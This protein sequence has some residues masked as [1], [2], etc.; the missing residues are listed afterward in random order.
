MVV[1][2]TPLWGV[3]RGWHWTAHPPRRAGCAVATAEWLKFF[4]ELGGSA[5][6][7]KGH[8]RKL[9]YRKRPDVANQLYLPQ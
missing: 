9:E 2:A 3:W 5:A 1:V 6:E 4:T 7:D 8:V